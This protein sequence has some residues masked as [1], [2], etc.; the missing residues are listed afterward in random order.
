MTLRRSLAVLLVTCGA[1]RAGGFDLPARGV[2]SLARGGAFVAG[3]DDADGLWQNPAGLA[4]LAGDGVRALLFDVAFLYQDA[5]HV[6]TDASGAPFATVTNRQPGRL[7]PTLAGAIGIGKRLVIAGGLTA[8]YAPVHDYAADGPQRYAGVSTNGSQT[9]MVTVGAAFVV[10]ERLRIGASIGNVYTKTSA[11]IVA[12]ACPGAMACGTE[13]PNLDAVVGIE[14]TDA[15]APTATLGVQYQIL[16]RV[17]VG[18]VAQAPWRVSARGTMSLALPRGGPF[19]DATVTGTTAELSWTHPPSLRAGVELRPSDRWRVE[20][21]FGAELWSLHDGT[22]IAP[23]NVGVTGPNLGTITVAPMKIPSNARTSFSSA[24]AVEWHGPS[25][26]LG[27][28]VAVETGAFPA[29]EVTVRA[30]DA[31]K[32]LIGAGGGWE[33]A[34]W[35]IG[36]SVGLVA[37]ADVTVS[38]A[39]A[40]APLLQPLRD[41]V[42]PSAVNAGTYRASYLL[43]GIRFARRW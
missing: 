30:L 3:A 41:P 6:R 18:L 31:R 22:T 35:Q 17:T 21:A 2:R 23:D 13:D 27:A 38:D 33:A 39:E 28:G 32:W 24:L 5:A 42:V 7:V 36:G 43:A 19:L 14:Q 10:D 29:G 34:G 4:H 40:R 8:P 20:G 1:A 9:V 26:M 16:P 15:L 11:R 12:S 37:L 25:V